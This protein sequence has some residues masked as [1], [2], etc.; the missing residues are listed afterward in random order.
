MKR[1]FGI[2]LAALSAFALAVVSPGSAE[3]RS[4]S[5]F[6]G[7]PQNPADYSCF[8]NGGGMVTNRC[9]GTRRFC[10]TLPVDDPTH[11]IDVTIYSPDSAHVTGCFAQAM[12][13]YGSGAG[14]TGQKYTSVMR[15]YEVVGLGE[16]TVPFAGAL[17][18]CCDI[19]TGGWVTSVQY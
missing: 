8:T 15:S 18:A 16:L 5:A 14:W 3:A 6:L 12:S 11:S 17:Y 4:L 2:G 13:R 19:P 7:Q 10:I 9:S 1:L